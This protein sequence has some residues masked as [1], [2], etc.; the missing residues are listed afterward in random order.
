MLKWVSVKKPDGKTDQWAIRTACGRYSVAKD[1]S[2]IGVF[3]YSTYRTHKHE[4]GYLPLGG[5]FD[6]HTARLRC[7]VDDQSSRVGP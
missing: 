2:K 3:T 1:G 6:Q 7:E 4:L 5:G